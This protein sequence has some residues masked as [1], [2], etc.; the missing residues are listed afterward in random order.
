M[1]AE[2]CV[3][4]GSQSEESPFAA[5]RVDNRGV[6]GARHGFSLF[7]GFASDDLN[8]GHRNRAGPAGYGLLSLWI[9]LYWKQ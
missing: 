8:G 9:R 1:I 4:H 2:I 6:G 5:T 3:G 7:G